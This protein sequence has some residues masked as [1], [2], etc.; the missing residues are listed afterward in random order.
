MTRTK[1]LFDVVIYKIETRVIDTIAGTDLPDAGS[2]HT[3]GK[4]I[5]TVAPRL[6]DNYNVCAVPAGKYKKGDVLEK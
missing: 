2:F 6:N 3:V 4:R 1:K 5:E